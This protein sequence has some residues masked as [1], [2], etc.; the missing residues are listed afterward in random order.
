MKNNN[1]IITLVFCLGLS[2]PTNFCAFQQQQQQQYQQN[3]Q[4]PQINN[5]QLPIY[6]SQPTPTFQSQ[7]TQTPQTTAPSFGDWFSPTRWWQRASSAAQ[8]VATKALDTANAFKKSIGMENVSYKI[9]GT[10]LAGLIALG[11]SRE[12]VIDIVQYVLNGLLAA[13]GGIGKTALNV[14][15]MAARPVYNIATNPK[16][17]AA[18][19][20]TAGAAALH[21]A[22]VVNEARKAEVAAQQGQQMY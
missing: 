6:Y 9:L 2:F 22:D 15:A 11:Y 21:K 10:A 13:S 16:A 8:S 4:Y 14:G 3:Y 7:S 1:F 17:A 20:L 19:A 18:I 12:Q 5:P